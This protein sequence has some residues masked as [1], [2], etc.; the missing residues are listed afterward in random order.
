MLRKK[1]KHKNMKY[2]RACETSKVS[3]AKRT[4]VPSIACAWIL[5]TCGN[6]GLEH[7]HDVILH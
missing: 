4:L 7:L 3:F 6:V 2:N 5:L 1:K